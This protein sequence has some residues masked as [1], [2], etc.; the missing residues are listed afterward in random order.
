MLDVRSFHFGIADIIQHLHPPCWTIPESLRAQNR[1]SAKWRKDRAVLHAR[2]RLSPEEID[3][4]Q[5]ER[6]ALIVDLAFAS[7][8]FY[9]QLYKSVGYRSGDITN[10]DA[11]FSLPSISKED[12]IGNFGS[13]TSG[14]LLPP[15]NCYRSRTSGSSGQILTIMKD[16]AENDQYKLM[17]LRLYEQMLGRERY[18]EEWSYEIYFAPPRHTSLNG[19]FPT[20]TVSQDCPPEAVVSHILKLKPK[21]LSGFASYFLR[22]AALSIDLDGHGIAAISTHSEGSTRAERKK[23]SSYFGVPVFDD[24]SS[25]ELDL[26]ATECQAG[27]YHLVEDNVRVDVLNPDNDGVGEIIA[28]SLVGMYMPFIRYRQGDIIRL[29]KKEK[30]CTCGNNFRNLDA[31]MGRTDQLLKSRFGRNIAADRVM[32]LIDR[33]LIPSHSQIAEFRVEQRDLGLIELFVV[34]EDREK[35]PNPVTIESF[36]AGL[37]KLF[38]DFTLIVR[39]V[40]VSTMPPVRSYKRRLIVNHLLDGRFP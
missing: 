20:F 34:P 18:P 35:G 24:Y 25:E 39:L 4:F 38:E 31:L 27:H 3:A 21:I 1:L 14:R 8:P 15:E 9:H 2:T 5:L 32:G 10:W 12:I 11:Y 7:N 26:I 17:C 16:E 22:M 29:S 36:R 6:I 23:I 37:R 33:T 30:N 19:A 28:T 13:F 40:E